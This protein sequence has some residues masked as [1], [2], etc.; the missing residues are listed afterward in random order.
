MA[1]VQPV[2]DGLARIVKTPKVA[3]DPLTVIAMFCLTPALGEKDRFAIK[4]HKIVYQPSN[5]YNIPI[6]GKVDSQ[7]FI[8]SWEGN[9]REEASDFVIAIEQGLDAYLEEAPFQTLL[10]LLRNGLECYIQSYGNDT[11]TSQQAY[12]LARIKADEAIQFH[13]EPA[14]YR[15]KYAVKKISTALK[16]VWSSEE[17]QYIL[18]GIQLALK[19]KN[20]KKDNLPEI[21]S[22]MTYLDLKQN[23]TEALL[24]KK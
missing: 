6:L 8:R 12:D 1:Y 16:N 2:Q 11:N 4:G 15:A 10:P 13:R 7:S 17:I 9:S 18:F 24:E 23:T 3:L 14:K 19:K 20:A 22:I 5:P 21:S